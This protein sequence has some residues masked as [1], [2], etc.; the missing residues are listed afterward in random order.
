M[1]PGNGCQHTL[2]ELVELDETPTIANNKSLAFDVCRPVISMLQVLAPEQEDNVG[3]LPS[4]S[5]GAAVFATP[6]TPIWPNVPKSIVLEKD[7]VIGTLDN[8]AEE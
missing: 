8:D 6:L 3:K 1:P 2:S 4:V 7:T 5:N